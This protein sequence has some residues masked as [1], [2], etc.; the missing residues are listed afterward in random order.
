MTL[1]F[2]LSFSGIEI[3]GINFSA[4]DPD[5]AFTTLSVLED[6]S[7][8][9]HAFSAS[10]LLT[11]FGEH[12]LNLRTIEN[13]EFTV[14]LQ[15]PQYTVVCPCPSEITHNEFWVVS[16]KR[17]P[18]CENLLFICSGRADSHAR[19]LCVIILP[20]GI[21]SANYRAICFARVAMACRQHRDGI[22]TFL[23]D[24]I[25]RF[26]ALLEYSSQI[27]QPFPLAGERPTPLRPAF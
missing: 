6:V 1:A 14:E 5:T 8:G 24:R 17:M 12:R 16:A 3:L 20:R 23:A 22:P 4:S 25:P 18:G 10:T 9:L 11:K 19:T 15:N 13:P 21:W 2:L 27:R 26:G 7:E